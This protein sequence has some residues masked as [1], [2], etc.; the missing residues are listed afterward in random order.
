[1]KHL[2]KIKNK[3]VI[4]VCYHI[5]TKLPDNYD[6][7]FPIF[8]GEKMNVKSNQYINELNFGVGTAM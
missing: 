1:M 6:V 2:K 5:K 7:F 4:G 8:C 3:I